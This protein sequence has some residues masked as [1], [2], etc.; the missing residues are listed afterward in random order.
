MIL[1]QYSCFAYA[2]WNV[3]ALDAEKV[4]S[5]GAYCIVLQPFY[6][7][8]PVF[9]HYT[10][11][12]KERIQSCKMYAWMSS[13]S[14]FSFQGSLLLTEIEKKEIDRAMTLDEAIEKVT[15]DFPIYAIGSNVTVTGI[16][17]AYYLQG[18][19]ED[20]SCILVPGWAFECVDSND[21]SLY[22]SY[23]TCFYDFETGSLHLLHY[24]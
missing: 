5:S 1:S 10:P 14:L 7:G 23:Y 6:N 17:A 19:T 9:D 21:Q 15:K 11:S 8:I 24:F 4:Q 16:C 18:S 22:E 2:P 13:D 3:V 12:R 20:D